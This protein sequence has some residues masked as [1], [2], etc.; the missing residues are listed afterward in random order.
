MFN[1]LSFKAT[2]T[3][4]YFTHALR[5]QCLAKGAASARMRSGDWVKVEYVDGSFLSADHN[6]ANGTEF[7]LVEFAPAK[8]VLDN[9]LPLAVDV[10]QM[11]NV[12]N[13]P[14][15]LWH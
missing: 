12:N 15:P 11:R 3:L 1:E 8:D 5:E 9:W 4:S 13:L 6:S 2:P 14:A 10:R 7:D